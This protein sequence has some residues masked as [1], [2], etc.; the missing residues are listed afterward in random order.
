MENKDYKKPGI[1]REIE[2]NDLLFWLEIGIDRKLYFD[3]TNITGNIEETDIE[4][5]YKPKNKSFSLNKGF[6]PLI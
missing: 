2:A 4:R 6:I 1:M 5:D 3:L